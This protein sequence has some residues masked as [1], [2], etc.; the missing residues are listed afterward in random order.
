MGDV[1]CIALGKPENFGGN[2]KEMEKLA[3]KA[4]KGIEGQIDTCDLEAAF[5]TI[6]EMPPEALADFFKGKKGATLDAE[7]LQKRL[8]FYKDYPKTADLESRKAALDTTNIEDIKKLLDWYYAKISTIHSSFEVPLVPEEGFLFADV[9]SLLIKGG[10]M[11]E[12]SELFMWLCNSVNVPD[13]MF[14][15]TLG[16]L[17]IGH[18]ESGMI[19]LQKSELLAGSFL[20]QC[21]EVA[22]PRR[23]AEI[24]STVK[25]ICAKLLE[26]IPKAFKIGDTINVQAIK[27]ALKGKKASILFLWAPWC[28]ACKQ[29]LPEL[30]DLDK[31]IRG[32]G[33]AVI[34]L[35]S[36][37]ED[38]SSVKKTLDRFKI[39]WPNISTDASIF[40][41]LTLDDDGIHTSIP[42]MVLV[43]EQGK[44]LKIIK[45]AGGKMIDEAEE[46]LKGLLK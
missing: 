38:P 14:S 2:I 7:S 1:K 23:R 12:A 40:S 34:G 27:D 37:K 15:G 46:A 6:Y 28:G 35:T 25:E 20:A 45:G 13:E 30:M 16:Q 31:T 29:S 33:G 9:G 26:S 24:D 19:D 10:M 3:A 42:T 4:P 17:I 11:Q 39:S 36:N 43:N 18:I 21:R 41:R 32:A 22:P 8:S 44:I 5:G